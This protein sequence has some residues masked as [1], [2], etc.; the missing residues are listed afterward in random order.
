MVNHPNGLLD[1]LVVAV[2]NPRIQ[3][4]LVRAAAFKNPLVKKFLGTLNLMPIY[5]IRDGV[6]EL[7][8]NQEIFEKCFSILLQG[9]ALMIFPEGS[10]DRRRTI[11]PLSKGFSRIIFGALE[12]NPEIQIQIV[13]V[14]ITY[15]NSSVYPSNITLKYGTPILANDYFSFENQNAET[16][17]LKEVIA[18][19]LKTL[20]VHIP[21]DK[22]Y[23][24]VLSKLN[25]ANVDFTKV[26]EVNQMIQSGNVLAK[27]RSLHMLG[28][29]KTLIILN[30]VVPWLLWKYAERKN[31]EI[32]FV[33]TFRFGICTLSFGLFYILQTY[34]VSYF[35]DWVIGLI[36]L[37][38][39][40]LLVLLY[41]KLHPTPAESPLE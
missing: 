34:L 29:L 6:K 30:S 20:T 41:S 36:Y 3:H 2:N 4:F 12:K 1:P 40:L 7:G 38:C 23:N 33:D 10:H 24:N 22:N 39:S 21:L 13:P 32:E 8:R 17:R 5:R 31:D 27:K 37:S 16:K 26:E 18:E 19:Q 15:Q 28:F 25:A 14:G 11:R 9:K 35:F